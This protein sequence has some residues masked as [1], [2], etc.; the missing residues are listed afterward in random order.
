LP[1]A[2]VTHHVASVVGLDVRNAHGGMEG[3]PLS[4]PLES[5]VLASSCFLA[6]TPAR[7]PMKMLELLSYSSITPSACC[8]R[9]GSS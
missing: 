5:R 9:V 7:V 4:R 6:K 2:Q 3:I 1:L 8:S